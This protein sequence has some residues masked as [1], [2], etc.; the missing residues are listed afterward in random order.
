MR[1]SAPIAAVLLLTIAIGLSLPACGEPLSPD[2]AIPVPAPGQPS[3]EVQMLA[4]SE[5]A[6]QPDQPTSIGGAAEDAAQTQAGTPPTSGPPAR[7]SVPPQV[8]TMPMQVTYVTAKNLENAPDGSSDDLAKLVAHSTLIV[9]GT[10]SGAGPREERV[11]G[12]LPDDPSK[13]DPNY[14]MIGNIYEVEVERYLKGDGDP[15]LPVIQS[16]GYDALVPGPGNTP[17]RLT[18][19]RD[20]SPNL[21]LGKSSRYLLFLRDNNHA[22]GLWMGTAHPYKFLLSDGMA[23]VESP[24]GDLEGAF[25]DRA[26]AEIV[27]LVKS[28][29]DGSSGADTPMMAASG[30]LDGARWVL[31]SLDGSPTIDGTFASLKVRGDQYG[32]FDGCNR[33]GGHHEDGAPIAKPDGTFSPPGSFHT[34]MLCEGPDGI[35]EQA[36][37]YTDAL[38]QGERFRVVGDRLEIIDASDEVR[39]VLVRQEPL[40][41]QPVDLVGTAWQ[42]VVDEDESGGVRVPTLAFLTEHIATGVTACRGYV[43]E[44]SASEGSVRFPGTSMT[45]PTESCANELFRVEGTYTDHFTWADEYSVDENTGESLFR[46]RTSRGRTMLFEP[47]PKA[48]ASVFTRRWSLTTFVEPHKTDYSTFYSRTTDVIPGTEIAIEFSE[49]GVS[50]S[51]GCNSYN[52]PLSVEDST[53]AVGAVSVTRT[54]CDDPERLMDQERRYLDILSR[55]TEFLIYGDRLSLLTVDHEVLLFESLARRLPKGDEP[56]SVATPN[57]SPA[58]TPTAAPVTPTSTPAVSEAVLMDARHYAAD[59]GVSLEEAVRRL[60]AQATIGI[61]GAELEANEQP[62]FGGLWI[63]HTPEY[64]VI[65][66]FTRDGEETIRPYIA[67]TSLTDMVEVREVNATL[68]ELRKAQRGVTAFIRDLG[69]RAASGIDVTNNVALLYLSEEGKEKLDAALRKSGQQLPDEVEIVIKAP[70]SPA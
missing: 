37:A 4:Q 23:M 63:Q 61:L 52:A 49:T 25:P 43:V 7:S 28:L 5:S 14:T 50:G 32:G 20:T 60:Q 39:L 22:P 38:M 19:G 13:P 42:L 35:M 18:R 66:A 15:T 70:P 65:V 47:L 30:I 58:P 69:I 51:A 54:W 34:E 33:F 27:G 3:G 1:R 8:T 48:V 6:S 68:E 9:I 16:I 53:I 36:D 56:N 45:G 2:V 41:G 10:T 57:P 67:G 62:T 24:V 29:A 55:G 12:R 46:I 17:G 40:P 11:P 64:K 26:E 31:E 21:L 59:V 44:H